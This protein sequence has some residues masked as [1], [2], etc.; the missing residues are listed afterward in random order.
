MLKAKINSNL[1]HK[2]KK[3]LPTNE[4]QPRQN[5]FLPTVV[6]H[7]CLTLF[8]CYFIFLLF[9]LM[10]CS[11]LSSFF[12]S[13]F[14]L[15]LFCSSLPWLWPDRWISGDV[16]GSVEIRPNRW[17][18]DRITGDLIGSVEI[19]PD[20]W[21]FDRIAGELETSPDRWRQRGVLRLVAEPSVGLHLRPLAPKLQTHA[22]SHNSKL[23]HLEKRERGERK[24]EKRNISY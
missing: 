20:R 7:L 17:R 8:I 6:G 24:R 21:R 4:P 16:T 3:G 12:L 23:W 14:F 10:F 19:W 11:S 22:H 18:R 9:S 15:S 1:A 2:P 5:D 13:S